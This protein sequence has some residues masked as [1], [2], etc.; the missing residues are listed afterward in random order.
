MVNPTRRTFLTTTAA[1]ATLLA[2]GSGDAAP[3]LAPPDKQPPN[4]QLPE[5]VKKKVGIAVVGLGQLALEEVIPAFEHCK[6]AR[7]AALVSGHLDKARHVARAVGLDPEEA[8]YSYERYEELKGNS[9]VDAIYIIL[10]NSMHA[11]FTI[12]GF[13]CGKHVLCEK[14]MAVSSEECKQM[15]A[16]A[17]HAQRKLMIAYR[18]H[19][20]PFNLEIMRMCREKE[21]GAIRSIIATNSQDVAAPNI[22]LSKELRG[23][24]L[25]DI[26]IYCLNATRYITDEEPTE[27][28]AY[29]QANKSDPRF[30]EVPE[31]Y[32]F[33]LAF[34]SGVVAH[35]GC[36]FASAVSRYLR[37][38]CEK[39]VIE[40]DQAFSYRGQQ[41]KIHT[42]EG[43][44]RL[45]LT[46]VNHF[47]AEMDAFA[48]AVLNDQRIKTPGEEGLA[49]MIAIE[50][51]ERSAREGKRL[52]L[53]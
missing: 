37:I 20:E 33:T 2:N 36:N 28:I 11:E 13:R 22:R 9:N 26:G 45:T 53:S 12:R 51:I 52:R 29:E 15:I 42:A 40:L 3:P 46:P 50:A 14:P 7:L 25:G 31:G 27:V 24:P 34:P 8:V 43:I 49:D 10:P 39:G 44:K 16:A 32:S 6:F 1:T 21:L 17:K 38:E 47:A 30:S 5:I 19:Y 4:L 23:G 48:T 18:L 35:C 41:L